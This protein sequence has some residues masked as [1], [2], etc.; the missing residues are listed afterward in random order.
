MSRSPA[1]FLYA[2]FLWWVTVLAI[3]AMLD[4]VISGVYFQLLYNGA[5]AT[6]L[7]AIEVGL[8]AC[9]LGV[10]WAGMALAL[11]PGAL[12]PPAL[13]RHWAVPVGAAVA[14]LGSLGVGLL[15]PTVRTA[16]LARTLGAEAL[17]F[18]AQGQQ[19]IAIASRALHGLTYVVVLAVLWWQM[20]SP[21]RAM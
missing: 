4:T 1:R 21:K 15:M 12:E 9:S 13:A 2:A 5:T 3:Q 7:L 6:T 17:A 10:L 8:A 20:R 18:V 11:R 14:L 19:I 16:L